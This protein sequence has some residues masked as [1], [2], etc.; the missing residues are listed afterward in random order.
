MAKIALKLCEEKRNN[1]KM[2]DRQTNVHAHSVVMDLHEV[3][4]DDDGISIR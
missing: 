3:V 1:D 4:N 2:I